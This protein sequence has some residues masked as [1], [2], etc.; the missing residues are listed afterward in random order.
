MISIRKFLRLSLIAL[1]VL[2]STEIPAEAGRVEPESVPCWFFREEKLVLRQTCIY[3]ST[4]WLGGGGRSL[5]WEDG[6][7]TEMNWGLQGRGE[8][9]CEDTTLDGIC[10]SEYFRNPATLTRLANAE[11]ERM[12][13]KNQRM[14][15]C[16]Q[17]RRNS[18]CFLR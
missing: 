18:V 1:A 7:K 14:I 3:E 11:V 13:T 2:F 8:R 15:R 6:V 10:G 4:S 17:A 9:P 16:V 5:L 12:R